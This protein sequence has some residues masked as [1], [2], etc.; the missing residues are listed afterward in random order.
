MYLRL[1]Q[2]NVEIF[3][4]LY[5]FLELKILESYSRSQASKQTASEI[6]AA[7]PGSRITA[8]EPKWVLSKK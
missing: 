7:L 5:W 3:I 2:T 4:K 1:L 8:Q 6:K